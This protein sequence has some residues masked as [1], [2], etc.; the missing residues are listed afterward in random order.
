MEDYKV[1]KARKL[2]LSINHSVSWYCNSKKIIQGWIRKQGM[3]K[4]M[5]L[6]FR[7]LSFPCKSEPYRKLRAHTK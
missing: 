2:S 1:N 5:L 3:I 4:L 6:P 7:S